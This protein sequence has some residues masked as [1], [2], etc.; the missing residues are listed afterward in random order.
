MIRANHRIV[1]RNITCGFVGLSL[2]V[3]L[4]TSFGQEAPSASEYVSRAEYDKLKA[5][6]EAMKKEMDALKTAV[7]QMAN[8]TAPAAPAEG[9]SNA[10]ATVPEGKQVVSSMSSPGPTDELRQEVETLKTQVKETFPGATKFLV[11]GYGTSTF[12][13]KSG[14]DPFFD[15]TFNAFFLWKLTD[16]LLFEGEVEFEFEDGN[17]TTNLEI[18]Q[19]SYLLND[20]MTIGIGRFLNPMNYFVERQHMGWVNKF[21][22]KPLAVYDGLLPESDL[23][24]QVRGVIPI[25]P[26]KLEYAAFVA[27]APDLMTTFDDPTAVGMLDFGN[28]ANHGG[29]FAVGGHVGFIPIPQL[30]VGYGIRRS[31][32]GPRDH[33]VEAILQSVDFNYVRDSTLLKGLINFRAQWVW[34]HVGHFVYDPDGSQGFGPLDFSNNRNGGYVQ[35]SYRPTKID[36]DIIKNF[37]PVVR[38]DRF[39]QL[40]TPVAFDEQRWSFGL[41]YWLTPSTVIKAAYELDDKNGGARDQDAF[42]LQVAVGF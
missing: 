6:H 39:N 42:L 24:V 37:E 13:A 30:E 16:R 19:A 7:Q 5:E 31:T 35:L 15:A 10:K 41:D 20:Y 9:P 8:G 38:Y 33:A 28:T 36:N 34:S 27:N 23:G 32:V 14:E 4:F 12:E 18:A 25:G 17:T 21:P 1:N 29:H 26:T 11:A 2:W 3:T 22:D 40:H